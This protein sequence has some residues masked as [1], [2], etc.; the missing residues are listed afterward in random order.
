[1]RA[2]IGDKGKFILLNKESIFGTILYVPSTPGDSWIVRE[3]HEGKECGVVYIQ[4]FSCMYLREK[5]S[6]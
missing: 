2:E 3:Y 5:Y 1:M 6:V 4:S